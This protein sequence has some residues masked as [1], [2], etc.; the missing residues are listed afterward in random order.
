[1]SREKNEAETCSNNNPV[2]GLVVAVVLR[3]PIEGLVVVQSR[4]KKSAKI[5]EWRE[6]SSMLFSFCQWYA[7]EYEIVYHYIQNKHVFHV[8]FPVIILCNKYSL[9]LR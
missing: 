1:L 2:V 9:W 6:R 3:I 7:E 4:P 8:A 5:S